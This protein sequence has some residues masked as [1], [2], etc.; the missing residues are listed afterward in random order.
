MAKARKAKS[1]ASSAK[2]IAV[3]PKPVAQP[4]RA[5]P[6]RPPSPASE[7]DRDDEEPVARRQ[8]FR[9]FDLPSELRLRIY[10]EVFHVTERHVMELYEGKQRANKIAGLDE[11]PDPPLDLGRYKDVD[12]VGYT[13]QSADWFSQSPT[14]IGS[15]FVP[16]STFSRLAIACTMKHTAS[17]TAS[18]CVYTLTMIVSS[19][20]SSRCSLVSL[21]STAT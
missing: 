18:Q 8:P 11:R 19:T 9:F 21:Q 17:S 2:P 20:P 12:A 16:V 13:R 4:P 5:A 14:S 1:T 7:E 6:P 15:S 3:A 10:E